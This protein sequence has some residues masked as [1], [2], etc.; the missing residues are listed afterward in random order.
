MKQKYK[1]QYLEVVIIH[2]L[3]ICNDTVHPYFHPGWKQGQVAWKEYREI[4]QEIV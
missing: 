3:I 4:V 2:Y 1:K